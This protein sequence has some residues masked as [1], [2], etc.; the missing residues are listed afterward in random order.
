MRRGE[1]GIYMGCGVVGEHGVYHKMTDIP[2]CFVMLICNIK[3]EQQTFFFVKIVT[4]FYNSRVDGSN[5]ILRY[6][7]SVVTLLII[8]IIIIIYDKKHIIMYQDD[9][10]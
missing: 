8:I 1:L 4:Y 7:T 9:F 10:H 6:R 5:Y 2:I 3:Y